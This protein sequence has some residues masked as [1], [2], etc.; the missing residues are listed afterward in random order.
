MADHKN[1]DTIYQQLCDSYRAIDEMRTK[2]LSFLPLVTGA[3]IA[4]GGILDLTS[5]EA[6]GK[7]T[8][9]VAEVLASVGA[10]GVLATIGLLSLELHGIKKC[11]SLIDAGK[12][13]EQEMGVRGQFLRRP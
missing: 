8:L 3:G 5:A 11:A 13:L 1:L 6:E 12:L 7:T 2:L 4:A 9:P 10:L